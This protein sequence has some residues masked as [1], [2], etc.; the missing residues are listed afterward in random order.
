LYSFAGDEFGDGE[1]PRATL[2]DVGGTLYGTTSAGGSANCNAYFC[3]TVFSIAAS[4]QQ[5]AVLHSFKG[6]KDGHFPIAGLVDDKGTLYGTTAQGGRFGYGTVFSI[7]GARE[8]VLYSF[9][10]G[11]D[12]ANPSASLIDVKGTL[13]G[14][15]AYG[16]G[17]AN[18]VGTSGA[19]GCG[20][21]FSITRAGKEHILHSFSGTDG[22]KPVARLVKMGP[23]LYGTT[24]YGGTRNFGTVFEISP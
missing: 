15:T 9:R 4:G 18:C 10:G 21:V 24:Y 20:T 19:A 1:E 8:K 17:S 6:G 22:A 16:G 23:N 2:A 13:Y 14:T 5:Y 12:G 3:G 7:N 11:S